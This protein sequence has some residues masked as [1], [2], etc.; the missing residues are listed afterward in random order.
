MEPRP[1]KSPVKLERE[2]GKP[3]RILSTS[4]MGIFV[5]TI[6]PDG[7]K[8]K[9]MVGEIGNPSYRARDDKFAWNPE[10][11]L[12][13]TGEHGVADLGAD[14]LMELSQHYGYVPLSRVFGTRLGTVSDR[15]F[16]K[17]EYAIF[18]DI[19]TKIYAIKELAK[20]EGITINDDLSDII[21]QTA[22]AHP[23]WSPED[24][25]DTILTHVDEKSDTSVGAA[26][27]HT[28]LLDPSPDV[29]HRGIAEYFYLYLRKYQET[30]PDSSFDPEDPIQLK[31]FLE[32]QFPLSD[33]LM[34]AY[35]AHPGAEFGDSLLVACEKIDL[36]DDSTSDRDG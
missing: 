16:G 32:E 26:I 35:Q 5:T 18:A 13:V 6:A 22:R 10:S 29:N 1:G 36:E 28:G 17:R 31:K 20:L 23:L 12:H 7:E 33:Q 8:I 9:T 27:Q 3:T 11:G 24:L 4:E 34:I 19:R 14:D 2:V 15:D 21:N 25:F 30:H